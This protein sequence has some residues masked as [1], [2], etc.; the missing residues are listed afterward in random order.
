MCTGFQTKG[1]ALPDRK[2]I[3][4]PAPTPKP[5]FDAQYQLLLQHLTLKG[6]QPK[7]IDAYSR[8]IRRIGLYFD[9]DISA[10]TSDQL[11]SYFSQPLSAMPKRGSSIASR[12]EADK[13][14]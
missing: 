14:R 10:L 4:M 11:A 13:K 1:S 3:N 5:S 8:A 9:H 2:V 7:T 6:L 12:S